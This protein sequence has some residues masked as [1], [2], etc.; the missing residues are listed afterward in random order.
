MV[1]TKV[2]SVEEAMAEGAMACLVK[3]MVIKYEWLQS[4][5]SAKNCA[6]VRSCEPQVKLAHF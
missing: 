2:T 6:V 1:N 4:V 3:N 5:N